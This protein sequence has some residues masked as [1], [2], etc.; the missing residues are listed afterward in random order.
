MT[1]KRAMKSTFAKARENLSDE[2]LKH[3]TGGARANS[4][5]EAAEDHLIDHGNLDLHGAA[6]LAGHLLAPSKQSLDSGSW[7]KLE[8]VTFGRP[9]A[10]PYPFTEAGHPMSFDRIDVLYDYDGRHNDGGNDAGDRENTTWP[11]PSAP[12]GS[13]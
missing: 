12:D 4:R 5:P 13:H 1:R 8:T 6:A 11:L 9:V 10:C 2:Q 3:V 7:Q